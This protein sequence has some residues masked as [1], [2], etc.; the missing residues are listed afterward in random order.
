MTRPGRPLEPDAE[1]LDRWMRACAAFVGAHLASLD[2]MPSWDTDDAAAV[3]DA[4]REPPPEEGHALEALL[5]RLEPAILKSFNTAGPGYLAFIPG[6]GIPAAGLAD[7]IACMTN[8]YVGVTAAAPALARIETTV[9]EW[10]AELMGYP[11]GAGGILTSGGSLSNLAAIVTARAALLPEDGFLQGTLYHSRE[12]HASVAKS[13]RIAGFSTRNLRVVPVDGRLRAI[14][15][16]LERMIAED[17][18]RGLTPFLVVANAGTTNTGA[19][20]PIPA[21]AEIAHRHGMWIHADAAYGGVFRMVA[22][23][24]LIVPGLERCDSITLDPHKG[25]FLP[26]GTGCLLV[27]EPD[28]LRRAHA[29]EAHYLQDVA[30]AHGQVNFTDLSPELSRDFRG[31]RLW[32]PLQLHGVA[33]FRVQ[34]EEKLALARWAH[35]RLRDVPELEMLDEPQ[36][37]VVAFTVRPRPGRDANA[38]GA[39]LLRRVNARRRV[40]LSSTILDGRYV[41][42][43][44]VLSFRTHEQRVREAVDA[45]IDEAGRLDAVMG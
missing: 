17:R 18:A 35:Q 36:L 40:F 11:A 23:G 16:A 29:S 8:R 39:E 37:S 42:R 41:L 9:I 5:A 13:A 14:P 25:L 24:E 2:T 33:A 15:E 26:Y 19:V 3:A 30:A 22:G 44:C 6:G 34:L 38:L 28:A 12:T 20:D 1:E 32:L 43:I 10:L 7:F 45:L 31:L 27:K 21:L 4:F